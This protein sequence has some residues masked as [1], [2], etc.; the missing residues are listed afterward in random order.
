MSVKLKDPSNDQGAFETIL[1][2]D[3]NSEII[4]ISLIRKIRVPDNSDA[5]YLPPDCGSFP[6][7]S[8]S[9][10]AESLPQSLVAKGGIFTSIYRSDSFY[11]II[12]LDV[13]STLMIYRTRSHGD[14]F[15]SSVSGL[16]AERR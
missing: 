12:I 5:Y 2:T 8:V 11:L 16:K 9:D 3:R 7:Y 14:Q 4:E 10:Y 1:V 13:D 6:L 15:S